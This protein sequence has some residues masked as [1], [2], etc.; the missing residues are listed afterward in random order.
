MGLKLHHRNR[1]WEIWV[2]LRSVVPIK[3]ALE[4]HFEKLSS[5]YIIYFKGHKLSSDLACLHHLMPEGS[6]TYPWIPPFQLSCQNWRSRRPFPWRTLMAQRPE[7]PG[8]Y[9]R[10]APQFLWGAAPPLGLSPCQSTVK[11]PRTPCPSHIITSCWSPFSSIRQ[12]A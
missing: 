10:F 1:I 3:V 4:P 9:S 11:P 2:K 8:V 7:D 6:S 12:W 5:G